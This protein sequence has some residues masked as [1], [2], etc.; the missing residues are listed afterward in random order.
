MAWIR[1]VSRATGY[2]VTAAR[3]N[4]DVVDNAQF[5]EG[6]ALIHASAVQFWPGRTG[7]GGNGLIRASV[8]ALAESTT[9]QLLPAVP[10]G[11]LLV[12]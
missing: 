4:Q 7:C 3:W 8:G 12:S 10:F 6:R 1:P 11:G 5:L 9:C 2:L